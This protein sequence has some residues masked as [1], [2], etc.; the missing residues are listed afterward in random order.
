[1]IPRGAVTRGAPTS[2]QKFI[3]PAA[4]TA[5][6]GDRTAMGKPVVFLWCFTYHCN[7]LPNMCCSSGRHHHHQGKRTNDFVAPLRLSTNPI[8]QIAAAA[9]A[10]YHGRSIRSGGALRAHRARDET[11]ISVR[12]IEQRDNEWQL[13]GIQW[14]RSTHTLRRRHPTTTTVAAA[15]QN[16]HPMPR[17]RLAVCVRWQPPR[18]AKSKVYV[19]FFLSKLHSLTLQS[20]DRMDI[21]LS[22]IVRFSGS[23]I[24]NEDDTLALFVPKWRHRVSSPPGRNNQAKCA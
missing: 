15:R 9:A 19:F 20:N 24:G 14:V 8:R 3:T 6:N 12:M 4:K 7:P 10:A 11:S 2:E 23:I 5:E 1:M 18:F 17:R 13:A 22:I 16:T 21:N